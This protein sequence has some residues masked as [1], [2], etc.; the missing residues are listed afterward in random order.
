[1]GRVTGD[2]PPLSSF[3]GRVYDTFTD[4]EY[5]SSPAWTVESGT[6]SAA[7]G[8]LVPTLTGDSYLVYL[9]ACTTK[10]AAPSRYAGVK[11]I[12][13]SAPLPVPNGT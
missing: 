9:F 1:M 4:G 7:T 6:W 11:Y 2:S 12:T 8:A 5:T 10:A 13:W 3:T